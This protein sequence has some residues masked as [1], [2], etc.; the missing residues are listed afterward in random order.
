M[1]YATLYFAPRVSILLFTFILASSQFSIERISVTLHHWLVLKIIHKIHA[2]Q[3]LFVNHSVLRYTLLDFHYRYYPAFLSARRKPDLKHI[4]GFLGFP[5]VM[6]KSGNYL[7]RFPMNHIYS[8]SF[9]V[10]ICKS[11]SLEIARQD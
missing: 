6:P 3:H 2:H 5:M 11:P 1:K 10:V 7:S 8:N 4:D 9:G